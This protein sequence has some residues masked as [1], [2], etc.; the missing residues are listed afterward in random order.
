MALVK[1]VGGVSALRGRKSRFAAP[2]V[3]ALA[4]GLA[5]TGLTQ[6]AHA[7][8]DQQLQM[9]SDQIRQL[10]A[11]IDALKK[12]QME[13]DKK[14][15]A[16]AAVPGPQAGE[17]P[18]VSYMT[19]P[20]YM[21]GPNQSGGNEFGWSSAD[22]ANTIELTGRVHFDVGEYVSYK[23]VAGL[24]HIVPA[25]N[26]GWDARRVR[27]GVLGRFATDW[28]YGLIADF[29]GTVD[30]VSPLTSGSAASEIENAYISYHGFAGGLGDV[31]KNQ[32]QIDIGYIDVP[33]TLA[34]A[35][36]SNATAFMERSSAQVVAT[37]FGGGDAR[38]SF[39]ARDYGASYWAG[40]YITGPAAG[41]AHN[42]IASGTNASSAAVTGST[43]VQSGEPVAFLGRAGYTPYLDSTVNGSAHFEGNASY[44]AEP[45][46]T[47][48][49]TAGG[50]LIATQNYSMTLSDRPELRID[51][52]SLLSTGAISNVSHAY[53]L[54][55]GAGATYQNF[56]AQG[57]FY[58]YQI[59]RF[60]GAV[61]ATTP[62]P[63]LSFDGG[64]V[65]ATYTIGGHRSYQYQTGAYGGVSPDAPLSLK[66]GGGWGAVEFAVRFSMVDLNDKEVPGQTSTASG[67]VEG[68][69]QTVV[70]LGVN[71]Y[72]TSNIRLM[73]DYMH[74]NF[75]KT[76]Y[77]ATSGTVAYGV[78]QSA[79]IDAV[80]ARFQVAF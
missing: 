26:S 2:S 64:Y 44:V 14:A 11:Q 18:A 40:A 65:E 51:P 34:E 16:A 33:F 66:E 6:P 38:A 50:S 74:T 72:A 55:G 31:N 39:G 78:S 23:P 15:A 46:A 9:L 70:G 43:T 45:G 19:G 56:F 47:S 62:H 36:S 67:G 22:G 35:Q 79:T 37:Q 29:G 8:D 80:A 7:A 13:Q 27:L 28:D 42:S 77:A 73:L 41:T 71:Y 54:G 3:V 10:Q 61:V 5:V 4:I 20:G 1:V 68:G 25:L 49:T 59:K 63:D 48:S 60:Q 17:K 58:D 21:Y 69:R 30:G 76:N 52:T 75:S 24:Q 53:V 57:E 12:S 32:L